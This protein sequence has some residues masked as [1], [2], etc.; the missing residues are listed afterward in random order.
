MHGQD[1]IRPGLGGQGK[2]V[3]LRR[4]S[5][6]YLKQVREPTK[7]QSEGKALQVG[8]TARAKALRC[9][10]S[11]RG[12]VRVVGVERGSVTGGEEAESTNPVGRG[13]V[14]GRGCHSAPPVL[15]SFCGMHRSLH[16]VRHHI[17]SSHLVLS[18]LCISHSPQLLREALDCP[19]LESPPKARGHP[20]WT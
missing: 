6:K 8:G 4:R 15:S 9:E 2:Y 19:V 7:W 13:W 1:L 16:S 12:G 14:R 20:Q 18:S 3:S 11:W 5:D 10:G 17:F